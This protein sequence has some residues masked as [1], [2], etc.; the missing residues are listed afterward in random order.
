MVATLKQERA[1]AARGA[2]HGA[3][4]A[5]SMSEKDCIEIEKEKGNKR[6]QKK[7]EETHES[8]P[9]NRLKKDTTAL[10]HSIHLLYNSANKKSKSIPE[11]QKWTN[12]FVQF[13]NSK[14]SLEKM[15]KK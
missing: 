3:V 15:K 13:Q 6:K 10:S 9:V 14:K 1:P 2:Q 4:G 8:V 12:I 5:Y 7:K 11:F